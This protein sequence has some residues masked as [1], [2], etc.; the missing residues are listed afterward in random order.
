M[1][2]AERTYSVLVACSV[3]QVSETLTRVLPPLHVNAITTV[4]TA[5]AARTKLAE[6]EFDI[7]IIVSP[8]ADEF[9]RRFAREVRAHYACEI[10]LIVPADRFEDTFNS[11]MEQGI[12]VT[13]RPLSAPLLAQA[14][15]T[16]CTMRERIRGMQERTGTLEQKMAEIRTVNHAK[17]LLIDRL[18]MTEDD[19]QHY[20]EHQA[21]NLRVSKRKLAEDIIRQYE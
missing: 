21:M 9:G 13:Q 10:L 17:W 12:L 3:P 15:R 1:S 11:V 2:F 8:L 19:A 18:R 14:I 7:L 5:A 6:Q 20:I 4:A 16:L